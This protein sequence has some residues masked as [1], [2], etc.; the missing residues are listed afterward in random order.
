MKTLNNTHL[1]DIIKYPLLT[2]KTTKLLDLGQYTFVVDSKATK[3]AIKQAVE[4]LFQVNVRSVN[5][6]L[7]KPKEKRVG[8]FIGKTAAYKRAIVTLNENETIDLFS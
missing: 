3:P 7:Y 2:D 1:F 8:R 6:S 4:K 5:T